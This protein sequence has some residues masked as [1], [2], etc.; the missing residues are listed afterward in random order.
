MSSHPFAVGALLL[1]AAVSASAD[2]LSKAQAI[3][4]YR[5]VPSRN[6]H[7]A[8]TRSDGRLT[9]GPSVTT[10]KLPATAPLLWSLANDG[11]K[12]LVGTGPDGRLLSIEP[13]ASGTGKVE[14]L[15]DLPETHIFS[16]LRLANGDLLAGTSPQ[17]TIV[18]ARD[19]KVIARAALPA[20]S[21]FDLVPLTDSAS[22]AVFV[23]TGNPGRIYRVDLA[24]FARGGDHE[25]KLTTAEALTARGITQI[26][27]IRDRNIRRLLRL[28][29]GRLIAG[30]AP[31]GNVYEFP[32]TGGTPRILVEN[33][34]AEVC[35]LLPWDGG[36]F[37]A[38]T[39]A[40][41]NREVRVNRP[42]P[43]APKNE[44]N[45]TN[46]NSA[47]DDD[48]TPTPAPATEPT[49]PERFGGRSQLLWFPDG[50][51]PETVANRTNMA[52]YRLVRQGQRVLIAG[53]EQGELLGYDPAVQR[54]L[55]YA[56]AASSQLNGLV[57]G[58][59]PDLFYAIGNNA[60]ELTQIDF[61]ASAPAS[62]ETRRIDLGIPA[63]IGQFQLGTASAIP[64]ADL[65]VE[66]RTSFG[67]DETE[68]WSA[69]QPATATD[70]GWSVPGLRGRYV[71][72][73]FTTRNAAFALD[74]SELNYLPQNRRPQLQ[75]FHII[76][77]NYALIPSPESPQAPS[78]T[79]GQILSNNRDDEKHRNSLASS[80][81][82]PQ[83]GTQL[84]VWNINDADNDNTVATLSI[85]PTGTDAWTDLAV[86]SPDNYVQFD[87]S[88]L[89]EGVYQTRLVITE[90]APRP[91]PD[92]LSA[93]FETDSL[94]IDRTP[95]VITTASMRR[96]EGRIYISV[97]AKDALSLLAGAE[98]TLNNGVHEIV[99][100]PADGILDG[101]D[102]TFVLELPEAKA[103]GATS[104]EIIVYDR[105][106]NSVA[107]RL[108][109]TP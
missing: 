83:P 103:S 48:D 33:R 77:P 78:T 8:A 53:G 102:E 25:E 38:I 101:R 88:H 100:Q 105:A 11:D 16:A 86:A 32:A 19:G 47:S 68:G 79:L 69:W 73:R 109:V 90:T 56:G 36:F 42:K 95:P 2:P 21:I 44:E 66:V 57:A 82:V 15:L 31:K 49:Q 9:R 26:G 5:D 39:F 97:R 24:T 6:L 81:V 75:D 60:A 106:D 93:T 30:S 104:V 3:D 84:I 85:R 71:Q 45:A 4:F 13:N 46:A 35:D 98:F 61:S 27:E 41:A 17:G 62:A 23:A 22:P 51:F 43:A 10:L 14:T 20:D 50:G 37:A 63:A 96:A 18:L 7:G 76:S 58:R 52:F 92:R 12:L 70:G 29:D 108:P 64:A 107:R 94:L 80:P 55:T 54:S 59:T 91:A 87:I 28:A 89:P 1:A 40:A 34:G 72:L 74:K 65:D 67:S 99:E